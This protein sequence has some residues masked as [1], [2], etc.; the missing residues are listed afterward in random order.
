MLPCR[1]LPL[2]LNSL[3]N[4]VTGWDDNIFG[5]NRV[6]GFYAVLF[7]SDSKCYHHLRSRVSG[8]CWR[9]FSTFLCLLNSSLYWS[10]ISGNVCHFCCN[11]HDDHCRTCSH[12][13]V[14]IIL[15]PVNVQVDNA[16]L[17]Q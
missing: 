3:Y 8:S 16:K 7:N 2:F 13:Y 11:Y 14:T 12:W 10:I 5:F 15:F 1:L 9:I 4:F 6:A 17:L